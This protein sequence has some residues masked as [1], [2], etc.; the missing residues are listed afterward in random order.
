MGILLITASVFI[1]II[2]ICW[3]SYIY[4]QKFESKKSQTER[5]DKAINTQ[6]RFENDEKPK[7]VRQKNVLLVGFESGGEL[8]KVV[9][10]EL[11]NTKV[12]H[13]KSTC[14]AKNL[15]ESGN[16]DFLITPEGEKYV[17]A[18]LNLTK[19]KTDLIDGKRLTLM[20]EHGL[21]GRPFVILY[22]PLNVRLEQYF[23]AKSAKSLEDLK[24]LVREY[25]QINLA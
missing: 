12:S 2:I 4:W 10:Q 16:Y 7:L 22:Q 18:D 14:E 3:I 5:L 19:I 6:A 24:L 11:G 21:G 23:S 25:D 8:E 17:D 9:V 15:L 1:V 13:A 20:A